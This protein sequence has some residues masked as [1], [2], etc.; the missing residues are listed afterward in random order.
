MAVY[1]IKPLAFYEVEA[2]H[3]VLF[4]GGAA[5]RFTTIGCYAWLL[6]HGDRRILVDTGIRSLEAVN[7]TVRGP[8]RWRPCGNP[9]MLEQLSACALQSDAITDVVLTHLH[10]DHCSNA[11]YFVNARFYVARRE[12]EWAERLLEGGEA[13]PI[14]EVMRFLSGLDRFQLKLVGDTEELFPDFT[15]FRTGGHTPGSQAVETR[16][17]LGR[18]LLTG[19]AVFLT[20]NIRTGTPIGLTQN[21]EESVAAVKRFRR[22]RGA[23]LPSHDRSILHYFHVSEDDER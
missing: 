6:L 14:G 10:Y 16:T 21:L 9:G 7:R 3:A 13:P 20:D 4:H 11:D 19:D 1:Q 12:W 8:N 15:V 5:D 17:Q 2:Q 18:T 22:F 23:V